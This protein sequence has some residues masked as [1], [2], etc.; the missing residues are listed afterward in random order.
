[1]KEKTGRN[2]P[3]WCG[4]GKKFKKCHLHRSEQEK[5]SKWDNLKKF[6]S[7]FSK[8]HCLCPKEH[9]QDCE[10]NIINAHTVSKSG[11]LKAI[12]RNGHVYAFLLP[13]EMQL[14]IRSL[15]PNGILEP[16]LAGINKASTF[17]GFCKAHD[18]LLFAPIEDRAFVADKEQIFLLT[19]RTMAR[20]FFGKLA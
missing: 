20:E 9:P 15:N 8:K 19:Y 6:K 10:G 3:C 11:N 1:M 2:S 7:E 5:N 18:K 14:K 13:I 16:Y 17:T 12:S 4:S